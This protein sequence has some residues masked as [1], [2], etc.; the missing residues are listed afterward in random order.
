MRRVFY[1]WMPLAACPGSAR[2]D[3]GHRR[4][5][6]RPIGRRSISF[7]IASSAAL[8]FAS[9]AASR[10]FRGLIW[11]KERSARSAYEVGRPLHNDARSGGQIT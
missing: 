8:I 7:L 6:R 3:Q 10:R 5:G 9:S 11:K 2:L 1:T 4:P